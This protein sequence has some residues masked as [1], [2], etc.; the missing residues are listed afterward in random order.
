LDDIEESIY[1]V[2]KLKELSVRDPNTYNGLLGQLDP[3]M[4]DAYKRIV[5]LAEK[6]HNDLAQKKALAATQKVV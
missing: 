3:V 5:Q 4:Q 6:K 1:F 2:E